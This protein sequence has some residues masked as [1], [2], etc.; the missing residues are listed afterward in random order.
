MIDP[1]IVFSGKI[2][3]F[4]RSIG[5][6]LRP[7]LYTLFAILIIISTSIRLHNKYL[8]G[9]L[10]PLLSQVFTLFVINF[11]PGFRYQ[12]GTC[13]IGIFC[14]A[15]IFLPDK[16]L[17]TTGLIIM[18]FTSLFY[19]YFSAGFNYPVQ[20]PSLQMVA[21]SYFVNIFPIFLCLG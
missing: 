3:F 19:F 16:T 12:L 21:H 17:I 20:R 10:L 15:L 13:F 9:L 18:P 5:F 6:F 14:F 11:A 8:L 2:W 1:Y 4:L 7:A